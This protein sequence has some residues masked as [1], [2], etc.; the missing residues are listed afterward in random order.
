MVLDEVVEGRLHV[1]ETGGMQE[2]FLFPT[3]SHIAV[4]QK[5]LKEFCLAQAV[6]EGPED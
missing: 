2:L 6:Q 1:Q 5:E 3:L 4:S